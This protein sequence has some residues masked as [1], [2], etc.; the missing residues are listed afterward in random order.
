MYVRTYYL[1]TA[2]SLFVVPPTHTDR[3]KRQTMKKSLSNITNMTHIHM[4][5]VMKC[6]AVERERE[7][8]G[9][10]RSKK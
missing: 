6:G 1:A 9:G 3:I 5:K 10:Q 2:V 7:G 4:F 8:R